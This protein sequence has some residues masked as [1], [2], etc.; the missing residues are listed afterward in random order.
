MAAATVMKPAVIFFRALKLIPMRRRKGYIYIFLNLRKKKIEM[1]QTY[2]HIADRDQDDQGE[3]VKIGQDIVRNAVKGH[4]STLRGQI[5][6][7][8]IICQPYVAAN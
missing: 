4:C 2:E 6:G 3:W 7:K 1:S 8:L 5:V